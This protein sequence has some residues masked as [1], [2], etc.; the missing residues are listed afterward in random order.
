[1]LLSFWFSIR[2]SSIIIFFSFLFDFEFLFI[3]LYLCFFHFFYGINSVLSDYVHKKH[4]KTLFLI[5]S[6]ISF[7]EIL[8]YFIEII[9]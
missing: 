5:F 6:R 7:L 8:R 9:F 2:L 4:L 1:M 3:F